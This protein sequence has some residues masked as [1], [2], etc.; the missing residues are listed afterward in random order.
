VCV[1]SKSSYP[2]SE[3]EQKNTFYNTS[4]GNKNSDQTLK[5][6]KS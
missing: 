6:K 4:F 2:C 1:N 3:V 5:T